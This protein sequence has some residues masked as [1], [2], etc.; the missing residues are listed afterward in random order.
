MRSSSRYLKIYKWL[1]LDAEVLVLGLTRGTYI[2]DGAMVAVLYIYLFIFCFFCFFL[3]MY[4]FVFIY[5]YNIIHMY[6]CVCVCIRASCAQTRG[7]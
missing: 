7:T 3:H 4:I 1:Y 6:I 5:I 2:R